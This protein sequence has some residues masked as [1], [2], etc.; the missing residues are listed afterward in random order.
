M[1]SIQIDE[2]GELIRKVR[3]EQGLRLEDLADE[4]I[5]PATIS[6]I[7]RGVP[8]VHQEK[9]RYVL[10]KL[11]LNPEDLPELLLGEQQSME[12]LRF[13]LDSIETL[14]EFGQKEKSRQ[15]LKE[16]KVPDSH[17]FASRTRFLLGKSYALTGNF[18]RSDRMFSN[19]IRLERQHD[20]HPRSNLEAC[21]YYELCRS[22]IRQNLP[23]Q[24]LEY[25][26]LGLR[27]FDPDGERQQIQYLLKTDRAG[28]LLQLSR[29]GES[30]K[31]VDEL[32]KERPQIQPVRVL[33]QLYLLRVRLLRKTGMLQQAVAC[34]REGLE[35][36]RI[37]RDHLG[38]FELWSALGDVYQSGQ[39]WI[40]AEACLELALQLDQL[41]ENREG[42]IHLYNRLGALYLRRK[43]W[44]QA[45][46]MMNRAIRL[47]EE[48]PG[49]PL[50]METLTLAGDLYRQTGETEKAIQRFERALQLSEKHRFREKEIEI[51]FRLAQCHEKKDHRSFLRYM[52][53]MYRV[54]K[55]TDPEPDS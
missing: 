32:W 34:A 39:N 21:S 37:N 24:A 29:F 51:L 48:G 18:K 50:L 45:E 30:L 11:R 38:T 44:E 12:L 6:N 33:I 47:G 55:E 15:K 54:Q 36:A 9:I 1:N 2:I 19:A 46:E 27:A 3:R 35:I 16:L 41:M 8:Y 31:L 52:E 10:S 25:T 26:H 43:K 5:S 23:E 42:L 22:A 4:N 20:H 40:E 13:R 53:N 7:E 17:P 28:I 14:L 49:T